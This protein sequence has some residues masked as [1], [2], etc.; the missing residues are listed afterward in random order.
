MSISTVKAA[1]RKHLL[2]G[3]KQAP[4]VAK[5]EA[6]LQEKRAGMYVCSVLAAIAAKGD[7]AL[8]VEVI[9]ALSDDF[10]T[11]KRGIA[12]KHACKQAKDKKGNLKAD[13]N[14]NPIYVVP[15]S[16]STAKSVLGGAFDN[17]I[18]LGTAKSPNTFGNIRDAASV[19]KAEKAKA[20]ETPDDKVRGKIAAHLESIASQSA[21]MD[22]KSLKALESLLAKMAKGSV[23]AAK[24]SKKAA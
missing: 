22:S 7:K 10:R 16:L 17:G 1:I 18:D 2:A 8:F 23:A 13:K 12:V 6:V 3:I 5:A 15:G 4:A 20:N 19:A 9:E 14:G 11:D 24:A 21:S